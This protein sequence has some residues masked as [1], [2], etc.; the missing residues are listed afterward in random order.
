MNSLRHPWLRLKI[1]HQDFTPSNY[2]SVDIVFKVYNVTVY[3]VSK[4]L[5]TY[6]SVD[7]VQVQSVQCHCVPTYCPNSSVHT[8]LW[9]LCTKCT[10]SLC[11]LCTILYISHCRYLKRWGCQMR[12]H[13]EPGPGTHSGSSGLHLTNHT[14]LPKT[15]QR[16]RRPR[17]NLSMKRAANYW[18]FLHST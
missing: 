1:W 8:P 3:I 11:T 13:L 7:I 15:I 5:C 14:V 6:S 17:L 10:M 9:T 18:P 16:D 2:F 12:E 4:H